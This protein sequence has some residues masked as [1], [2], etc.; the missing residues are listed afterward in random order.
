MLGLG[1]IVYRDGKYFRPG[2][3]RDLHSIFLGEHKELKAQMEVSTSAIGFANDDVCEAD[4]KC[5]LLKF[6]APVL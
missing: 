3:D 1:E 2:D 6:E 4:G 5:R